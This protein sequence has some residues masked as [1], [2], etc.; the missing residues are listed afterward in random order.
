[1]T[2][3]S[4]DACS[5][6]DRARLRL[7]DECIR[8]TERR[9]RGKLRSRLRVV[10][11]THHDVAVRRQVIADVVVPPEFMT[12]SATNNDERQ[13][14]HRRNAG[15]KVEILA[16]LGPWNP[17]ASRHSRIKVVD[18]LRHCV[19]TGRRSVRDHVEA[20]VAGEAVDV[21]AIA[22]AAIPVA[23]EYDVV[24]DTQSGARIC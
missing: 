14:A 22:Q 17:E 7:V 5:A 2:S 3:E 24:W 18:L 23:V 20:S 10:V 8:V 11:M 15:R 12:V 21:V 9:R 6:R 16:E 19:R 4:T 13:A 1:M